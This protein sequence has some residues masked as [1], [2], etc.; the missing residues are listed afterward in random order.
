MWVW[1][2]YFLVVAVRYGILKKSAASCSKYSSQKI[3]SILL[4]SIYSF[5]CFTVRTKI[6]NYA[7][8]LGSLYRKMN[9]VWWKIS[10]K[11]LPSLRWLIQF[12]KYIYI[13]ENRRNY[14]F[15]KNEIKNVSL[16]TLLDLFKF[17]QYC[18]TFIW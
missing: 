1:L 18:L 14:R 16:S 12:T 13:N 11:I 17:F 7:W 8:K 15:K 9:M 6:Q 5:S 10:Q 4:Y 2:E 3:C